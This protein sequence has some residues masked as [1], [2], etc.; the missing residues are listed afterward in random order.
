MTRPLNNSHPRAGLAQHPAL[1]APLPHRQPRGPQLALLAALC[2]AAFSPQA[3]AQGGAQVQLYGLV[4]AGVTRVSGLRGGSTTEVASGI[5]EGSRW[6][7]RGNED[8][9]GGYRALFTLEARVEADTGSGSSRPVTWPQLPDRFAT[10]SALGLNPALNP[11]VQAVNAGVINTYGVN[12]ANNAFDRQV[13]LG[14]VTP[15]GA[16]LAGRQ[17]TPAYEIVVGFDAMNTQ[18]GLAVGQIAPLPAGFDIRLS[19]TVQ[20][21]IQQGGVSASFMYGAGERPGASSASRFVGGMVQYKGK[22]YSVGLGHNR[23]NNDVGAESLTNTVVGGN[24]DI[25]PGKLSALVATIRDRNPS[26]LSGI[27]A[28]LMASS[29]PPPLAV[30]N[31][32][33]AA[34]Q[35]A[36]QQDARLFNVGYR[37]VR[38][39]NTVTFAYS[40]YNDRTRSDADNRSYG[41]AYSYALSK[42]TDVNAVVVRVDNQE[43]G[44]AAVGGNGYFGGVT[45]AAGVDSTSLALGVRHRF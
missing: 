3:L 17:Y 42:R 33:Q 14:L 28:G 9:G 2:T 32:I 19:N 26:G 34:Y 35:R 41:V 40:A 12:V 16:V 38:G 25:G 23:R 18:S 10:A 39:A 20:Y 24:L 43:R 13:F 44:Q 8:L 45:R 11:A 4:D 36:Y 29:T 31:A 30:A 21:R 5:M 15:V 1:I 22:G 7:M 27:A 37:I 6:G